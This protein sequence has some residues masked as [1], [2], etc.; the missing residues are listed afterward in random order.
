MQTSSSASNS[1]SFHQNMVLAAQ[2]VV[3]LYNQVNFPG[4]GRGLV[5]QTWDSASKTID[6][7]KT[8]ISDPKNDPAQAKVQLATLELLR[9]SLGPRP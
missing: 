1:Q 4:A 8:T 2:K 6:S 5:Q 3:G 7:A 9:Q